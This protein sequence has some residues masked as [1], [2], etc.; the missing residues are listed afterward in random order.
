ME[1]PKRKQLQDIQTQPSW[2]AVE[3]FIEEYK[4]THLNLDESAKRDSD[5][6]TI[7]DRAYKEGGLYHLIN[8]FN[9]LE[10]EARKY[11]I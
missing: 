4:K 8:F 1:N 5:F 7:W 3:E 9:A 2:F 6:N 10:N 11:D